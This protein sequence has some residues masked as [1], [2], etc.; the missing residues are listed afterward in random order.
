MKYLKKLLN[1]DLVISCI[2]LAL[3]VFIVFSN[4]ILRYCFNSPYQWGEEVEMLLIVWVIWYGGSAAF[5]TGNQICVDMVLG[6]LPQKMQKVINVLI[7][8]LSFA[9]ILFM[10]RQG[11]SYV[12][13]LA[14]TNRVTE[15]LHIPRAFVYSCM[16]AACFLMLIN[17]TVAFIR[18][19]KG[20][21]N[22]D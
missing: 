2:C 15:T 12:L 22:H 21:A 13:Q 19:M 10:L 7:F 17:L 11:L 4:V 1:I 3:L 18:E 6:L 14:D 8:I 20:E 5:R 16:P 9:V